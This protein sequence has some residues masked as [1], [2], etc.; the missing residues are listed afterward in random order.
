MQFCECTNNNI[1]NYKQSEPFGEV[2]GI[3]VSVIN[4][5][6]S[7]VDLGILRGG[8][9]WVL[10]LISMD[11]GRNS[12]GGRFPVIHGAHKCARITP[13]RGFGSVPPRKILVSGLLRSFL[14]HFRCIDHELCEPLASHS[15]HTRLQA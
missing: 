4:I 1:N 8:T 2:N 13:T 5:Y 6:I 14:M 15:R 3:T 9:V 10:R 12:Q 11:V 7:R